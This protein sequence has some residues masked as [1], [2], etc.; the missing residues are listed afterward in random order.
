MAAIVVVWSLASSTPSDP[1]DSAL[2]LTCCHHATSLVASASAPPLPEGAGT[3]FFN[4]LRK[5]RA[6]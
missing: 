2:K 4:P 3:S 1:N 5:S 6:Q